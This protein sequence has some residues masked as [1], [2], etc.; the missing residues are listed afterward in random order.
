M[1]L[2]K[3]IADGRI[4]PATEGQEEKG[5]HRPILSPF[6]KEE[7]EAQPGHG[8]DA[9]ANL[10][11]AA[12][13]DRGVQE[14]GSSHQE[15][16]RASQTLPGQPV[17][18]QRP[19]RHNGDLGDQEG[20]H[21]GKEGVKRRQ[22][23]G[24][25]EGIDPQEAVGKVIGMGFQEAPLDGV[26]DGLMDERHVEPHAEEF[27]FA[28]GRQGKEGEEEDQHYGQEVAATSLQPAPETLPG[29]NTAGSVVAFAHRFLNNPVFGQFDILLRVL[30]RSRIVFIVLYLWHERKKAGQRGMSQVCRK[31]AFSL[32]P[33]PLA[34]VGGG[35]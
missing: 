8:H 26:P 18:R 2:E 25:Q 33:L 7:E 13:L 34:R 4:Q 3:L 14:V 29:G 19:Q 24:H 5:P 11:Q 35:R 27:V 16:G 30:N 23:G 22:P 10:V 17:Q 21:R 32:T 20:I 15:A 6:D 31:V 28:H 9:Q 12:V 1:A